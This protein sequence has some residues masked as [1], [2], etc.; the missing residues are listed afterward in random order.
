MDEVGQAMAD[1]NLVLQH[2]VFLDPNIPY[3]NPHYLYLGEVTDLR[4]LIG[5]MPK[6]GKSTVSHAID[7]ALDSSDGWDDGVSW[8]A[9]NGNK[10]RDV[11]G[12]LL[13]D[14]QL[15]EYVI[16]G[17][18]IIGG[19]FLTRVLRS[20]QFQGVEFILGRENPYSVSD[21]YTRLL[22][23]IHYRYVGPGFLSQQLRRANLKVL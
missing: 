17:P 7:D 22:S 8:G 14:T 12:S 10:L 19:L 2:P 18:E 21:M 16:S 13:I 20:H 1:A 4:H 9:C 6:D 3:M 15:K 11:L 23:S 5:P